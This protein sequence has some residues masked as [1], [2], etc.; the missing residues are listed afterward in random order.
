MRQALN[1]KEDISLSALAQ[2][3]I[4]EASLR[5]LESSR[6]EISNPS[7]INMVIDNEKASTSGNIRKKPQGFKGT[8]KARRNL[9]IMLVENAER[10]NVAR[11][12]SLCSRTN[13]RK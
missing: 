2:H 7:T 8:S 4:V 3:L 6:E 5:E 9:M 1:K 11:K 10:P 13:K 12:F